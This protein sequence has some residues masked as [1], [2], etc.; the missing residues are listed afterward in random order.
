MSIVREPLPHPSDSHTPCNNLPRFSPSPPPRDGGKRVTRGAVRLIKENTAKA[1]LPS[2]TAHLRRS[3]RR[4]PP[5]K[6]SDGVK[7]LLAASMPYLHLP[8][9][10]E[11]TMNEQR[12]CSPSLNDVSFHERMRGATTAVDTSPTTRSP[13]KAG[14]RAVPPVVTQ[15]DVSNHAL[16]EQQP[17]QVRLSAACTIFEQVDGYL[18]SNCSG[19]VFITQG[20]ESPE[21]ELL[22]QA[23]EKREAILLTKVAG[24]QAELVDAQKM[25]TGSAHKVAS[26]QKAL[27]EQK[28][29]VMVL[30]DCLAST[31]ALANETDDT[32]KKSA[33]LLR[34]VQS[35]GE[36]QVKLVRAL[37]HVAGVVVGSHG[38]YAR[39]SE[40]FRECKL[41]APP[42]ASLA[43][44][45]VSGI[46]A[47]FNVRNDAPGSDKDLKSAVPVP[48]GQSE[49]PE[50][51]G[52]EDIE[53]NR[54]VPEGPPG[55]VRP[56]TDSDPIGNKAP[57]TSSQGRNTIHMAGAAS[58]NKFNQSSES[59][60]DELS[61]TSEGEGNNLL[62]SPTKTVQDSKV[63][64]TA[65]PRSPVAA[66]HHH[67]LSVASLDQ[68]RVSAWFTG[69]G[70]RDWF[71]AVL[72]RANT[73]NAT[74]GLP[75]VRSSIT[76][77]AGPHLL[78]AFAACLHCVAPDLAR[79]DAAGF[80]SFVQTVNFRTKATK[81][82]AYLRSCNIEL[83]VTPD[84]LVQPASAG[85]ATRAVYQVTAC[86]I[87]H[88]LNSGLSGRSLGW[89]ECGFLAGSKRKT[90]TS[91][92]GDQ[93]S[94]RAGGNV[95]NVGE[96]M[97]TVERLVL[98]G[99]KWVRDATAGLLAAVDCLVKALVEKHSVEPD[100][101]Q[102]FCVLTLA[103]T[104]EITDD[105]QRAVVR[106]L[107]GD[108]GPD[109][110]KVFG[111]YAASV[112]SGPG[113]STM[114]EAEFAQFAIDTKIL[115][116]AV[117]RFTLGDL[118]YKANGGRDLAL[119]DWL[120]LLVR[121]AA[122]KFK[123]PEIAQR[124]STLVTHVL[125][126]SKQLEMDVFRKAIYTDKVQSVMRDYDNA[127][128]ST[129]KTYAEQPKSASVPSITKAAYAKFLADLHVSD[130]HCTMYVL[131][132]IF[133]QVQD[134]EDDSDDLI[135]QEFTEC[136]VAIS[137]V[138]RPEPYIPMHQ[139]LKYFLET[140]LVPAKKHK[141]RK[142][143]KLR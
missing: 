77:D 137:V 48:D 14:R 124:V 69:D 11:Q 106:E 115:G 81:L 104:P 91:T 42:S 39:K 10:N 85:R 32:R 21:A 3:R 66:Q 112:T 44:L 18:D 5:P 36:V 6:R 103:N 60:T 13:A 54:S 93:G 96:V 52:D 136:L 84:A 100:E 78:D 74:Q 15:K 37:Q 92:L 76:W 101:D 95:E 141:A 86:L 68:E 46:G 20:N 87:Y 122:I 45:A 126:K 94:G 53:N 57:N 29:E 128:A 35:L 139:K 107:L 134:P 109:L 31:T 7:R 111:F 83:P 89:Q 50:G 24:L 55:D 51:T 73:I 88:R 102:Q 9:T 56:T 47:G 135:F 65:S 19:G 4:R 79:M 127:I 125:S 129:F 130:S 118:F 116:K 25:L 70:L 123:E 143:S 138:K 114:N 30:A 63:L 2:T 1:H 75:Q 71:E 62:P 90:A 142:K 64:R 28:K 22:L 27:A 105:A 82:L 98:D 120:P 119:G 67:P 33:K 132:E 121:L 49:G 59:V 34:T 26:L 108:H 61:L 38:E 110:K 80:Q 17:Q 12:A 131:D 16:W 41:P 40:F 97:D 43:S 117:T 133:R 23:A 72:Q 8:K 113:S 58:S 140:W 99:T